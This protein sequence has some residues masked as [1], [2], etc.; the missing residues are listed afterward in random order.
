MN[1]QNHTPEPKE[2]WDCPTCNIKV[3]AWL[4]STFEQF[5]CDRCGSEWHHRYDLEQEIQTS[6]DYKEL[7]IYRDAL[8]GVDDVAEW[9][10]KVKKAVEN[11]RRVCRA[12]QEKEIGAMLETVLTLFPKNKEPNR[13]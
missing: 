11:V 10:A 3:D 9:M 1:N 6:K 8:Q 2:E 12:T 5:S 7:K 4:T 13:D